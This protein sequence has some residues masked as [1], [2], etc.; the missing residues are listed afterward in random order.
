MKQYT[1]F[2]QMNNDIN[3]E[4][5]APFFRDLRKIPVKSAIQT[6]YPDRERDSTSGLWLSGAATERQKW[7]NKDQFDMK[8]SSISDLIKNAPRFKNSSTTPS[9]L[10]KGRKH[11]QILK[12]SVPK[13]NIGKS[14]K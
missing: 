11:R 6:R 7:V 8:R 4:H 12:P 9:S 1:S 2:K 14:Q 5:A 13:L 3:I 10:P